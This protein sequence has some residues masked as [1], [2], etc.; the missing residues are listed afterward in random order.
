MPP[1]LVVWLKIAGV[2]ALAASVVLGVVYLFA[3]TPGGA[4]ATT[5]STI[6]SLTDWMPSWDRSVS[7]S[8][9]NSTRR[10]ADGMGPRCDNGKCRDDVRG[11]AVSTLISRRFRSMLSRGRLI[12]R[13]SCRKKVV[14]ITLD[15]GPSQA[16]PRTLEILEKYHVHATFFVVGKKVEDRRGRA[17][18]DRMLA[19]G[20]E[21]ENHTYHHELGGIYS[22]ICY[23][24]ATAGHQLRDIR[25]TDR[26]LHMGTHFLRVPGGLFAPDPLGR[27]L[28]SARSAGKVVVN[29][30]VA[31]D[32]PGPGRLSRDGLRITGVRP[33][34][35]L[36]R[37]VASVHPGAIVLMHP[38]HPEVAPYTLRILG[39]F[40]REMLRRGY[41]FVTLDELLSRS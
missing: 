40:I 19:A 41:S 11:I 38:E 5:M 3:C 21:V 30:D 39:P 4:G 22:T 31:G 8:L 10:G 17:W 2:V 14:A 33:V 15:D 29:W 7:G 27:T 18:V 12:A 6:S 26:S 16:T 28:E 35:L 36:N 20:H 25:L 34:D 1:R 23:A 9:G 37:Y 13:G 24:T 32:T